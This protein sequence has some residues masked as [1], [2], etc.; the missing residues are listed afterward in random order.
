MSRIL[1]R[2]LGARAE[3]LHGRRYRVDRWATVV[4]AILALLAVPVAAA[5]SAANYKDETQAAREKVANVYET[6]AVLQEDAVAGETPSGA[7]GFPVQVLA[8][9]RTPDG[10]Q[11]EGRIPVQPE[12][13][14]G[15]EVPV[16]VDSGGQ[17]TTAP[18]TQGE[19]TT[20]VIAT[21]AWNL[22]LMVLAVLGG[23][24][25]VLWVIDRVRMASWAAEWARVEPRWSRRR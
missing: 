18:K 9:W 24:W 17:L 5:L 19:I 25:L 22:V 13:A 21:G 11:H 3:R 20:T 1:A 4:A 12:L 7:Y 2:L 6:V 23:H 15:T 16:W 14:A 8:T 10:R